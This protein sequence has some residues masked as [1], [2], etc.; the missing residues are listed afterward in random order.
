MR[1]ES[2]PGSLIIFPFQADTTSWVP[3][4][5]PARLRDR[6]TKCQQDRL[7]TAYA[8]N[9]AHIS[10][11]VAD[12]RAQQVRE[13]FTKTRSPRKT[14]CCPTHRA[15]TNVSYPRDRPV[16]PDSTRMERRILG[17]LLHRRIRQRNHRS[18]QWNH[19][20]GQTKSERLP[21]PQQQQTPNAGQRRRPRYLHTHSTLKSL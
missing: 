8:A 1:A 14:L 11:A 7:V 3:C 10:G 2:L 20:T 15:P 19:Q 4:C 16:E 17:P 6:L 21:Q 5:L 12:Q 9:E 13:L 18:H